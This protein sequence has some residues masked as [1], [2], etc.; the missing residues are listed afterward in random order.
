MTKP[1]TPD[2][3]SETK[4]KC[5]PPAVFEAFNEMIASKFTGGRAVVYQEDV[6][7]LILKKDKSLNNA[8]IFSN[9]WLNIEEVYRDAGWSVVYDKPAYFENYR[10]S[11][12]FSRKQ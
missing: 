12:T 9:G 6:L 3:V 7:A 4:A 11:F 5:F 1:I 2:Q 10:A 8:V